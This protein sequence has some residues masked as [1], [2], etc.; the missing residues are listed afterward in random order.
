MNKSE[1]LN[2]RAPPQMAA[3][4]AKAAE[5]QGVTQSEIIRR[6]LSAR[7]GCDGEDPEPVNPYELLMG[8]ARGDLRAQ[9]DLA[10]LAVA[11]AIRIPADEFASAEDHFEHM[12]QTLIEG[13]VFARMAATHGHA[14]DQGLFVS[15]GTLLATLEG[16]GC[17]SAL[18]SEIVARLSMLADSGDEESAR[19]LG[20][21]A[22]ELSAEVMEDAKAIR[23]MMKERVIPKG[24]H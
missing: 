17:P 2:F 10:N 6:S 3:A 23:Q 9:R 22:S 21:I 20:P 7:L 4:L 1:L 5:E 8:A 15:M 14:S 12:R 24:A 11:K 16:D 18:F 13:L 19:L